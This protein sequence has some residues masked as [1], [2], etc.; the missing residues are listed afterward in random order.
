MYI[1]VH[2]YTIHNVYKYILFMYLG[3]GLGRRKLSILSLSRL[4]KGVEKRK[5][6]KT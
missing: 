1:N 2:K 5:S 4:S 6:R 3:M